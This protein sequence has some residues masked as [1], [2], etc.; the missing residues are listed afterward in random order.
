MADTVAN[1][2]LHQA[3]TCPKSCHPQQ[4]LAKAPLDKGLPPCQS[5]TGPTGIIDNHSHTNGNK[6]GKCWMESIF[7]LF[8]YFW[9]GGGSP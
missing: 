5:T 3:S 8:I 1:P 6:G 9:W 4:K 7:N 2:T